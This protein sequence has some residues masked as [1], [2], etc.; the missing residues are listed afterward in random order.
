MPG[1]LA[2]ALHLLGLAIGL[3][4]V[5]SRGRA[6]RRVAAGDDRAVGSVLAADNF[7]GISALLLIGTGLTRL[8]A[9][10]DK[11]PDFYLYN[12]LF[13]IKMGLFGLILALE[14]TPMIAFI[15]WR[16]ALGRGAAPDISRAA[17]FVRLNDAETALVVVIPF[18]AA[19][20][21]RGLWLIG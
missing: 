8:F 5:F 1:A 18:A 3:G 4:A 6:L 11:A 9:G 19:M 15:R 2:S 12:W 21:A 20:M 10:L 17:A 16:V 7:W 14:T 13:R